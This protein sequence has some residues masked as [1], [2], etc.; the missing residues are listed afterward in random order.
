VPLWDLPVPVGFVPVGLVPVGLVPVAL[1]PLWDLPVPVGFVPVGLVP[2]GIVPVGF[3]PVEL[4]P[5][6]LVPVGLV[7]VGLV[8]VGCASASVAD[9]KGN[10]L[11]VDKQYA[12]GIPGHPHHHVSPQAFQVALYLL[13]ADVRVCCKWQCLRYGPCSSCAAIH[14]A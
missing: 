14:E 11:Q 7:P 9:S 8:P 4:V 12:R 2:V 10:R 1:V 6:G 5:V 13:V 3:V